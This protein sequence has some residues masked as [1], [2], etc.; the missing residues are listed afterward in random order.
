MPQV[1]KV[2]KQIELTEA[3]VHRFYEMYSGVT[4][5]ASLSWVLDLML[6]KFLEAHEHTPAELAAIGAVEL[7]KLLEEK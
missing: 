5:N 1:A 6:E 2:R 7:K 4:N 3:N